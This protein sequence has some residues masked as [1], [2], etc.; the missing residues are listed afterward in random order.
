M[1]P[2]SIETHFDE[3]SQLIMQEKVEKTVLHFWKMTALRMCE[4]NPEM[5]ARLTEDVIQ[6]IAGASSDVREAGLEAIFQ[7]AIS[8]F[9]SQVSNLGL[10]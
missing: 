6:R 8:E 3:L 5:A 1:T 9:K 7:D 2:E 10:R 4:E